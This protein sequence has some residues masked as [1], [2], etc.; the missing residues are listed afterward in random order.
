MFN[1]LKPAGE[2]KNKGFA[3]KAVFFIF[4]LL[5]MFISFSCGLYTGG[6][7]AA[8]SGRKTISNE[9]K[10][11]VLA[12]SS[13]QENGDLPKDVN[14][15]LYWELW[16][17][18]KEEYVERGNVSDEELFYGSLAGMAASLGDPYTVFMDPEGSEDFAD[19]L[20][21]T[22]QG[23]GCEVGMRDD[24]LTV[25]APIDDS[26]AEKAGLLSGDKIL[27]V[28]GE[29]TMGLSVDAAVSKIRGEKGTKVVLSIYRE[30]GDQNLEV[31]IIRDDIYIKSVSSEM[32]ADGLYLL[33]INSFNE[34]TLTLFNQAVR[35][36]EEKNPKG[37]ILDLRNNP[38]GFL[39]TSVDVA[40][41]WIE[42]GVVVSE[43]YS[44]GQKEEHKASGRA[45]LK[46]YPTIV[47]V[48]GGSA[49]ASEIVAGALQDYNKAEILGEK[50]FGKGSVQSWHSLSD[51]SS[52][53][54]TTA[55]W[56]T[57]NGNSI[58]EQGITPDV[59]VEY[60]LEDY[61]AGKDPQMEKAIEIL[62][63]K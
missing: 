39:E 52:I 54:I 45:R 23:I 50:T 21:G 25:I 62:L 33:E 16:D 53:K 35:E 58:N 26:P 24:L 38:G 31:E 43:A 1:S 12:S 5:L 55:K 6:E 18:L 10:S 2:S 20:L 40:G 22:F 42:E 41:E 49:S 59:A 11:L 19:E 28:D 34:D 15:D 37:I 44:E 9:N 60:T 4:T 30:K 8:K 56:L 63:N 3:K 47:L 7:T 46:D 61:E 13:V 32:R 48:D 27:A 57:P 29:S 17:T 14:F 51:G 36:I